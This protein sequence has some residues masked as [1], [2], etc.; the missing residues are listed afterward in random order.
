MV[1]GVKPVGEALNSGAKVKMIIYEGDVN[2]F[3]Y[4]LTNPAFKVSSRELKSISALKSPNKI[5]A[6]CSQSINY[7]NS[8]TDW[9]VVLDQVS[10]PGNLGTI[11][12]ICDWMG[13]NRIVCSPNSVDVFNP[14]VVQASMGSIFR[15]SLEYRELV[16]YFEDNKSITAYGADMSGTPLDK[17]AFPEK[18]ILVMGSESHGIS[19]SIRG[20]CS[21]NISIPKIGGGESLNVAVSTGIILSHLRNRNSH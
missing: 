11:I 8:E 18:G 1:E 7:P 12:R 16:D 10:D 2:A 3:P 6:V 5:I 14:K 4:E 15:I 13:I 9:V 17:F 19:D 21:E 20:Y